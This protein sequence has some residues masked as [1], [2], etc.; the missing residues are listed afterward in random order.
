MD[1]DTYACMYLYYQME[2]MPDDLADIVSDS[3]SEESLAYKRPLFQE[4]KG[5][6]LGYWR[7]LHPFTI[8]RKI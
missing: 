7:S 3:T 2:R 5:H 4:M 8:L 1:D 6:M